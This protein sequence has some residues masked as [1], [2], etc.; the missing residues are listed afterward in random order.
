MS[1]L[2]ITPSTTGGG[3]TMNL[4]NGTIKVPDKQGFYV[5]STGCGSGKPRIQNL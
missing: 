1:N 3:F 4:T 5:I 2:N